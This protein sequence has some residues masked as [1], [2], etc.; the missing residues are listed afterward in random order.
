[1]FQRL[2]GAEGRQIA[3]VLC[4]KLFDRCFVRLCVLPEGPANGFADEE[5]CLVGSPQAEPKE[6]LLVSTLVPRELQTEYIVL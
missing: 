1:M 2:F 5:V 4:H 6:E 3:L